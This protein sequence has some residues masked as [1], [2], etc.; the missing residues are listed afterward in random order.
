MGIF[1]DNTD[2]TF[3]VSIGNYRI[4]TTVTASYIT[5]S[6]WIDEILRFTGQWCKP[7]IVGLDIEWCPPGRHGTSGENPVALLQLC[8]GS[9]CLLFQLLHCERIPDKL[10]EFFLDSRYRFVGSDIKK[11]LEKLED[12]YGLMAGSCWDD[13]RKLAENMGRPDLKGAS[14]KKLMEEFVGLQLE[15]SF[16]IRTSDWSRQVLDLQQIE[17]GALDAFASYQVGLQ[18]VSRN[19]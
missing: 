19:F 9:R 3:V 17:Y 18:L 10:Y 13:L 6:Y 7:V 12:Q 11:D 4:K 2:N 15:K 8:V 16:W 1:Y 14:L 5:A